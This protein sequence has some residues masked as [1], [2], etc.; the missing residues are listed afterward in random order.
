[1]ELSKMRGRVLHA[2]GRRPQ[3]RQADGSFL[4]LDPLDRCA[5]HLLVR[6]SADLIGCIRVIPLTSAQPCGTESLLGRRRVD[7]LLVDLGTTRDRAGEVGRWMVA[8]EYSPFR[9]GLRLIAGI[10]ALSKKLGIETL[11]ATVGTR[12]GQVKTLMR[13][14]GRPV[15][16]L[17]PIYSQ[18]YDDD[19]VVLTFDLFHPAKPFGPLAVA[20]ATRLPLEEVND[21]RELPYG[22][23][24][25]MT[26][27]H[28]TGPPQSSDIS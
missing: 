18:K 15:P 3:F 23:P 25:H 6:C 5:F 14:G 13:A 16:G 9:M 28:K 24:M 8:P 27:S 26:S 17:A 4:D 2:G 22:F 21:A 10:G 20:S 11:I 1:M 12:D 7:H 19:L